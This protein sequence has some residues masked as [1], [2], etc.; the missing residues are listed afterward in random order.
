MLHICCL[1]ERKLMDTLAH[2]HFFSFW[3]IKTFST[4]L[5]YKTHVHKVQWSVDA[6]KK[7]ST[8]AFLSCSTCVVTYVFVVVFEMILV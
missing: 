7:D 8:C 3:N 1:P 4:P 2:S 5:T 6:C